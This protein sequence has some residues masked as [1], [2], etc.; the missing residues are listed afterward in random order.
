M[1]KT[2]RPIETKPERSKL[3]SFPAASSEI[4]NPV[5]AVANAAVK[6]LSDIRTPMKLPRLF[7]SGTL[8]IMVMRGTNRA[9]NITINPVEIISK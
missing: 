4:K 1:A 8:E 6:D 5:K 7:S 3:I 2:E 9:F